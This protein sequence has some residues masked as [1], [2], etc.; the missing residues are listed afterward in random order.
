VTEAYQSNAADPEQI[1]YATRKTKDKLRR[2]REL[3]RWSLN[4]AEGREL[5]W[6]V[7]LPLFGL[8]QHQGGAAETVWGQVAL[9][10]VG[11]ALLAELTQHRELYLQMQAEAFK[12]DEREKR[13]TEAVRVV[14]ASAEHTR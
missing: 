10:N 8:H 3:L 12:R 14:R 6:A 2:R 9:H 5:W 1:D 4:H 13:E 11:C 7:L